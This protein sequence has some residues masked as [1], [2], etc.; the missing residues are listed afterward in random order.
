MVD[1]G[2][3]DAENNTMRVTLNILEV[4]E[5]LAGYGMDVFSYLIPETQISVDLQEVSRPI[6]EGALIEVVFYH[7]SGIVPGSDGNIE[8]HQIETWELLCIL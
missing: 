6:E 8:D 7:V 3:H 5:D 1:A 4:T 2:E